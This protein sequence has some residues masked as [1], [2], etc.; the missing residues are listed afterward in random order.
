MKEPR[1]NCAARG[2]VGRFGAARATLV[3]CYYASRVTGLVAAAPAAIRPD[4]SCMLRPPPPVAH[5]VPF[6]GT[7]RAAAHSPCC[8]MMQAHDSLPRLC[9]RRFGAAPCRAFSRVVA[10]PQ[11]SSA[12]NILARTRWRQRTNQ[13]SAAFNQRSVHAPPYCHTAAHPMAMPRSPP[14]RSAANAIAANVQ[15]ED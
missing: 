13:H 4:E 5:R 9:C 6:Q 2:Q 12:P 1:G 3:F 15:C 8:C 10:E 7:P 14:W 11:S